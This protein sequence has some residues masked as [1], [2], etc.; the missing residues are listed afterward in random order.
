[1]IAGPL[2]VS[3]YAFIAPNSFYIAPPPAVSPPSIVMTTPVV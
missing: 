3:T 2:S 1:V